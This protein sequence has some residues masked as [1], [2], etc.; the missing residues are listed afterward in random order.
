MLADEADDRQQVLNSPAN[1][2]FDRHR[3]VD[4]CSATIQ[5]LALNGELR[6][7]TGVAAQ[8]TRLV[9]EVSR[10]VLNPRANREQVFS[11]RVLSGDDNL[12]PRAA[13]FVDGNRRDR[14]VRANQLGEIID[15]ERRPGSPSSNSIVIRLIV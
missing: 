13:D 4:S 6:R 1:R 8:L 3:Q 9:H 12:V 11:R 15:G 14:T 5:P 7:E 2:R 10:E